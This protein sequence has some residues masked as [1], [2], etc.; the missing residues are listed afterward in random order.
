MMNTHHRES[1]AIRQQRCAKS[2]FNPVRK[3]ELVKKDVFAESFLSEQLIGGGGGSG[4]EGAKRPRCRIKIGKGRVIG[5]K[6]VIDGS[7]PD[8]KLRFGRCMIDFAQNRADAIEMP[9]DQFDRPLEC[10]GLACAA[11]D[12]VDDLLLQIGAAG[13][14]S[15]RPIVGENRNCKLPSSADRGRIDAKTLGREH[16]DS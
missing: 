4:R 14:H 15:R 12:R 6:W 11:I 1:R 5:I 9:G 7:R 10:C 2:S 13:I 16:E 8:D 3:Q